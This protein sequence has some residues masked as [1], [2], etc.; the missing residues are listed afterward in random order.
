MACNHLLHPG[1]TKS[2][3]RGSL[4][5]KYGR[6]DGWILWETW[7]ALLCG[8]YKRC[9]IRVCGVRYAVRYFTVRKP[10]RGHC[11]LYHAN[12][13]NKRGDEIQKWSW[14]HTWTSG[15]SKNRR[16]R[17]SRSAAKASERS[18]EI[19]S[20][21]WTPEYPRVPMPIEAWATVW[22]LIMSCSSLSLGVK[23]LRSFC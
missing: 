2:V 10:P 13:L 5:E 23:S 19:T 21:D 3:G 6:S 18:E 17:K 8:K 15:S 16:E 1:S 4:I 7:H 9:S 22:L 11:V 14:I 12:A 20:R